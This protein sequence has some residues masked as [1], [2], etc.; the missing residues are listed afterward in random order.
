[1]NKTPVES[2]TRSRMEA[3]RIGAFAALALG[4]LELV[5]A[6]YGIAV[7]APIVNNID[8]GR[9]LARVTANTALMNGQGTLRAFAGL[10]IILFALALA[11]SLQAAAPFA[12][13]GATAAAVIGGALFIMDTVGRMASYDALAQINGKDHSAAAAAFAALTVVSLLHETAGFVMLG[14][15][16]LIS[17]V[18]AARSRVISRP[19]TYVGVVFGIALIGAHVT[20]LSPL[21]SPRT[22]LTPSLAMGVVMGPLLIVWPVWLGVELLRSRPTSATALGVTAPA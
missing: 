22:A 18:V 5:S 7:G 13:R 19:L 9:D 11:E 14:V 10:S 8:P 17:A 20:G 6:I 21:S 3:R 1:M 2:G 16:V 12:M 15:F 4:L